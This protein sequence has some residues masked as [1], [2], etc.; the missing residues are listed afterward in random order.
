MT[1]VK[2]VFSEKED[3][4]NSLGSFIVECS[5]EAIKERGRFT[6]AFS[7]GSAATSVCE[8]LNLR[9]FS[10][11]IDWSKWYIFFCDERFVD[12]THPDSNYKAINDGLLRNM[13]QI[14]RN[15]VFG[16][17]KTGSVSDA[18]DAYERDL[19]RVF[20][21]EEF[22]SF[23]LLVLG[24]GPDGHICSLFPKHPLLKEE[25]KWVGS[26]DNSPKPPPQRI[27]FTLKV[28]N[29]ARNVLFFT[30]GI[31]KA[32]NI[33]K[34]IEGERTES[35]PASLVAPFTL[36]SDGKKK[37]GN[38]HWFMDTPAASMLTSYVVMNT[39]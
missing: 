26:I 3:L 24:M 20:V 27:T 6:V 13:P 12:L 21:N 5:T 22:P 14:D 32:A 28:V 38:V 30:T 37:S 18:A 2:H 15:K 7:G 19:R 17:N 16:L 11:A 33:H 39:N 10:N 35:V 34:A 31:G 9:K 8:C 36:T 1:H 23:D 29:S 25:V 4:A